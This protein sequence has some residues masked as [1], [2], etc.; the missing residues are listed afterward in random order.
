MMEADYQMR[1]VMMMNTTQSEG[2]QILETQHGT[3]MK[4]TV[5]VKDAP[6]L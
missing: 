2:L 4:L 5:S 1:M 6:R 3:W